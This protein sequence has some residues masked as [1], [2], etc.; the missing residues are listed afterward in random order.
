M[1]AIVD[2]GFGNLRSVY[3]ALRHVTKEEIKIAN[4]ASTIDSADR[5]VFP[6][7]G[8]LPD[9]MA[10][11]KRR[12]IQNA[13]LNA[14]KTK[15][16]L[17]ICLGLQMLFETSEEGNAQGFGIFKGKV[18]R[19]QVPTDF[20][21]PHMG[22]NTVHQSF[23]HPI[24]QGIAQDSRFYFVHSFFV[25]TSE[26]IVAATT[27]YSDDFTSAIIANN[28]IAVQFHP[29]KGAEHGLKLMQNFTQWQF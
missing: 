27:N 11:I 4:N 19:F 29:E 2:Y 13:I 17:G 12:G 23:E 28:C 21:I 25:Q 22:W 1:I 16:F 20:K 26:N 6:G 5:V 15:P 3:Q 14:A 9:A 7:Q 24:W 10:E 8:A 18:K